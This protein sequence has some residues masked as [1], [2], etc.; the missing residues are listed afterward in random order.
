MVIEWEEI[1]LEA[2]P[3]SSLETASQNPQITKLSTNDD[4]FI[5]I[6]SN[7]Q[8]SLELIWDFKFYPE[9][10]LETDLLGKIHLSSGIELT[11]MDTKSKSILSNRIEDIIKYYERNFKKDDEVL[12]WITYILL[13]SKKLTES[14]NFIQ[15][16]HSN[17][18]LPLE[19]EIFL[20]IGGV[21]STKLPNIIL[22]G[23]E[24]NIINIIYK[25][26]FLEISKYEKNSLY[27]AVL[28]GKYPN[29]LGIV[30]Q[31][32]NETYKGIRNI[33]PIYEIIL[34]QLDKYSIEE[35]KEFLESYKETGNYYTIYKIYKKVYNKKEISEWINK[36]KYY[37]GKNSKLRKKMD[38]DPGFNIFNEVNTPGNDELIYLLTPFEIIEILNN[39]E[40]KTNY[41]NKVFS[42]Y[43]KNSFSYFT[44]LN[45]A[46]LYFYLKDYSK[47]LLYLE[48]SGS[49]KN[50]SEVLY[51]KSMCFL[52]VGYH[53]EA[54]KILSIL[55]SK[56]PTNKEVEEKLKKII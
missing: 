55:N 26:K 47:F 3:V 35:Q 9:E 2:E 7:L 22:S 37:N 34:S 50:M 24:E 44:N 15:N 21:Y 31:L 25:Y 19:L 40:M 10:F 56:F 46:I 12:I 30:F 8:Q 13:K 1:F 20:I 23:K 48:R 41:K 29:F 33:Y 42:L 11:I 49:L 54:K 27:D 6:K 17:V 43:E 52:E 18:S 51:L 32:F 4:E 53:Q 45:I 28:S 38:E 16:Y 14:L 36:I 5:T 39:P